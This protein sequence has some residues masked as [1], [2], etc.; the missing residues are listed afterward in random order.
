MNKTEYQLL[1]L[2]GKEMTNETLQSFDYIYRD[3]VKQATQ[4]RE[5]YQA[6]NEPIMN[7][8]TTTDLYKV[9]NNTTKFNR[10]TQELK[11]KKLMEYIK[12]NKVELASKLARL[13]TEAIL[14]GTDFIV[15]VV[16]DKG[17]VYETKY[18]E[19][20]QKVFD[21]AYDMYCDIIESTKQKPAFTIPFG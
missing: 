3:I 10:E 15:D 21:Q 12:I 1:K 6:D 17:Q 18:S 16:N 7:Q 20:G 9:M 11:N 8:T 5:Q 19:E 13:E 2:N 14:D 4:L